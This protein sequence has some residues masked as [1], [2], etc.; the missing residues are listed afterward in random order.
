M[1][2]LAFAGLG[3]QE[4]KFAIIYQN[5]GVALRRCVSPEAPELHNVPL[6]AYWSAFRCKAE[7][8]C[9]QRVFPSLIQDGHQTECADRTFSICSNV[10]MWPARSRTPS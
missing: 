5:F 7:N 2:A 9:S 3:P 6:E 8:N 4:T 1:W 10:S